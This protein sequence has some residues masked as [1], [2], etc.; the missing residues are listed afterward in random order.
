M[1]DSEGD[2]SP[3][4]SDS[5]EETVKNT[6]KKRK[7]SSKDGKSSKKAKKSSRVVDEDSE[8][9]GSGPKSKFVD[10]EASESADDDDDD[11]VIDSSEE[12]LDE[13][14]DTYEKD[15]FLVGDDEDDEE[16]E[17]QPR[18]RRKKKDKK[19]TKKRSRLRHGRDDRDELD[20]DDLDLI[21]ENL[22]KKPARVYSDEDDD[23]FD[24]D[25]ASPRK[26]K[27]AKGK[28]TLDK[29]LSRDMFGSDSED[30]EDDDG[31]G[32]RGKR[33]GNGPSDQYMDEQDYNS[34]DEFIVSD[35]DDGAGGPRRRR[36]KRPSSR[37]SASAL[38]Q[39][40]SL[41]QLDE[42]EELF[43]DAEAF[44][45]ATRGGGVVPSSS[46]G[47][48]DSEKG[49]KALLL[50]KYEPSV[51]KEFHMTTS[52]S[53][54]RER[55]I[56]ERLQQ[57]YKQ[58]THF[59]DAE[60]RMEEAEWMVDAVLRKMD[61]R[62]QRDKH[63]SPLTFHRSNVV[64]AIE[65]VLKFYH[66]DKLEPP[67]VQRYCKEYWKTAGL[68]GDELYLIQDL[69]LKWDKLDRKRR[70]LQKN[71]EAAVLAN[72]TTEST[73]VRSCYQQVLRQ[74][75]DK[76]LADISQ[77]FQML[78]VNDKPN[79]EKKRPGRRTLYQLCLKGGLKDLASQFT[80]NSAILGGALVGL[81]PD[82]QVQVPTPQAVLAETCMPYLSADFPSVNDVLKGARHVA[83]TQLASDPNVRARMRE[84]CQRHAV[85]FTEA[86]PKGVEEVDEFHTCHGLQYI[87]EMPV[88]EMMDTDLYVKLLKGEK[89]GVLT[90]H[91]Q[92][93]HQHLIEP[94]EAAYLDPKHVSEE[95][96]SQRRDI[97][98]EA[99]GSS[100]VPMLLEEIKADLLTSAQDV[101]LAR[102]SRLMKERLLVRPF[103][104]KDLSEPHIMGVFV[105]VTT[106]E[107]IAHVVAL[108]ENGDVIDKVQGRCKTPNCLAKLTVTL[109][110]F[111]EDHPRLSAV[112]LNTSGGNKSMDVGELVDVVRNKIRRHLLSDPEYLHVTFVKDD[113]AR[114][115]AKSKRAEV[116]F[117][118]EMEGT[119]AAIGLA[120][121]L[122]NPLSELCAIWGF[123][124]LEEPGR[125]KELLYLTVH[126]L[127]QMVN[128]EMLVRA[129]ERV[130][131]QVVNK[132]GIDVNVS[133]NHSH[134]SYGLQ[135]VA[136]LGPVKAMA[137][138]EKVRLSGHIEKR[139]D[140]HRILSDKIVYRNCAGVLR[141][142]ERDALKD[143]ALNPLDDTRIH[144]ESYYMAVKICGDANNNTTMD[145]YDPDQYSYAVEDTMFQSA[146]AIK[147]A[148]ERY[149]PEPYK[150]LGDAEIAD[151]LADLDLPAYAQR[152]EMQQ[153]GLKLHTLE[154]IKQ[155]LRYPYFDTRQKYKDPMLEDLFFL[156]NGETR[157]TLRVGMVVPCKLI[158]SAG[159][160]NVIVEL[161][162]GIRAQ[163]KKEHLPSFLTCDGN[164]YLREHGFP[165]GM[166][167][168]AK[169]MDIVPDG[170][171]YVLALACDDRS[172]LTMTEECF[173]RRSIPSWT[174]VDRV[175]DDSKARYDKLVNKLP[176]PEKEKDWNK[177]MPVNGPVRKKRQI[178]HPVFKNV[179]LKGCMTLMKDM[180]PGDVMLR[181]ASKGSDH[182]SLTWK[183]D[184]NVYRHFDVHELDKPTEGRLGAKLVVKNETY[185]SIDELIARLIDPM[186]AYIEEIREH[187]NYMTGD[188]R[189]IGD[190]LV[191]LKEANPQSVPWALHLYYRYP[192][193]FSITYVARTSPRS[194][195]FI[196]NP[197]GL[198][199]FGE[200]SC[201][202]PIPSLTKA[203]A[204][205]KKSASN[206]PKRREPPAAA[207]EK[208]THSSYASGAPSSYGN[209][210]PPSH[211]SGGAST[212]S[213]DQYQHS[214]NSQSSSYYDQN[215]HRN[216][217][218]QG[219][220][221]DDRRY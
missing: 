105:D 213:R 170:D 176:S 10:D 206:P 101:V 168:N 12:E 85:V 37:R 6:S 23:D 89:E 128:Q 38:P 129:Y 40:P 86:T 29:G 57:L 221:R 83:A 68:K 195:H 217:H 24:D 69:D 94:L 153:K 183:I 20:R 77:A 55:D 127:Q 147:A 184:S 201:K 100:L 72:D 93:E 172:I 132:V 130:F 200:L 56:P 4:I 44:L 198:Q 155:E 73:T 144:P 122:R 185:D 192:G 47:D 220:P 7:Q 91:F 17:E 21:Q 143:A 70:V 43:G 215:R 104:A 87:K 58:R 125:G 202:E 108:D 139:Q 209:A 52:D 131:I 146:T 2:N 28:Q 98:R 80:V 115:F 113:V 186:N 173:N 190:R 171:R 5:E 27:S 169:I 114:M 97:V 141:I 15:G 3:A 138:I 161:H 117:P 111:L 75:Q 150:R 178:A 59:P 13:D 106:D 142:R 109:T 191:K 18:R 25:I 36:A 182:L 180:L 126:P 140:L 82:S 49:K 95:W 74:T 208:P 34:E 60:E 179:S 62:A 137:L 121:Y 149:H 41:D 145:L 110:S 205:F 174:E 92:I 78:E 46:I 11:K 197:N 8:D 196:V 210:Q 212:Y 164:K 157:D 48:L 187:K 19:E 124:P 16:E 219:R 76:G 99:V 88:A 148:T 165:R 103:E 120:R 154:S 199:F 218:D 152:L 33:R 107:P 26:K 22:G 65:H 1:P 159:E 90:I 193:C 162:S 35:D 166:Q 71:V 134:S 135:F 177:L 63:A 50:D 175:I 158:K 102:C 160:N 42:A 189:A 14:V 167:V 66:M 181:P 45:E 151:S 216:N 112:V 118:E 204:Y 61:Q 79:K 211:Y 214:S 53:T 30:D 163:L 119:R 81:V 51:L 32:G 39:G 188:V 31:G 9:D 116:E 123:V 136:G 203:I 84:I 207:V 64:T 54:V 67:Y 194:F 133:A 96:Q 156:L